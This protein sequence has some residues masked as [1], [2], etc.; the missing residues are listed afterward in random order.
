MEVKS[1]IFNIQ[2]GVVK[3]EWY[4]VVE[5]T[6]MSGTTPTKFYKIL[7]INNGL[8]FVTWMS[9]DNFYTKEEIRDQKISKILE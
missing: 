5:E 7:N 3:D 1:K 9:I 8:K 4:E 2:N 6:L